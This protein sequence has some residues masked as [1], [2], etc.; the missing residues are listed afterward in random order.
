MIIYAKENTKN[1]LSGN[2]F[3]VQQ[4]MR[5]LRNAIPCRLFQATG[6]EAFGLGFSAKYAWRLLDPFCIFNMADHVFAVP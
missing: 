3:F 1:R 6:R 5:L 2:A 4:P